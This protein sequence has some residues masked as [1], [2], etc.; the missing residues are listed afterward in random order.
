MTTIFRYVGAGWFVCTECLGRYR[1][2][3]C[4]VCHLS[5]IPSR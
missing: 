2:P 5:E 3:S 1:K 4:N